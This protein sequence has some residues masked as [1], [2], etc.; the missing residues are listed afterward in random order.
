MDYHPGGKE[1][2]MLAAGKD[3]TH[4]FSIKNVYT[5]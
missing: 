2:L 5:I 4:L 1:K 3:C